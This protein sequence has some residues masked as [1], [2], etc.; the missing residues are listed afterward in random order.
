MNMYAVWYLAAFGVLAKFGDFPKPLPDG[1][2][3][4]ALA[5]LVGLLV[6]DL[7]SILMRRIE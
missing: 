7:W 1:A 5:V 3:M 2:L 4:V 6:G